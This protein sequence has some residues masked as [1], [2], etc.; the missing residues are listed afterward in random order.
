MTNSIP[1]WTS[2]RQ[3]TGRNP[4]S[5]LNDIS[6]W[7]RVLIARSALT[8]Q[9]LRTEIVVEIMA[10]N[11]QRIRYCGSHQSDPPPNHSRSLAKDIVSAMWCLLKLSIYWFLT[12]TQPS[13]CQEPETGLEV[14]IEP[15]D[16]SFTRSSYLISPFSGQPL[17]LNVEHIDKLKRV[18]LS[19]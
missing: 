9:P 11:F 8:K 17:A 14:L 16:L 10:I 4:R 2:L 5:N 12:T 18:N 1:I 7:Y 15:Q 6:V 3:S 19:N 13:G